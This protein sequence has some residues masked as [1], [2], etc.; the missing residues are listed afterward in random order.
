MYHV[1][2]NIF[3]ESRSFSHEVLLQACVDGLNFFLEEFERCL[4]SSKAENKFIH[5]QWLILIEVWDRALS[6][7]ECRY[8][9]TNCIWLFVSPLFLYYFF[10]RTTSIPWMLWVAYNH[11]LE[12]E[13]IHLQ[14]SWRL[15]RYSRALILQT[16][17]YD[18]M[19]SLLYY[20]NYLNIV[21]DYW[22]LKINWMCLWWSWNLQQYSFN[23]F[24][25]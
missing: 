24:I 22:K 15:Q 2:Y 4:W 12:V 21:S 1:R 3:C 6:L 16:F 17:A 20:C 9:N 10:S 11:S 13:R 8:C 19:F 23:P 5:L 25:F 7:D 18:C 14:W